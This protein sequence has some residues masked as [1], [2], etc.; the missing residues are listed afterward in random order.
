MS[1][2]RMPKRKKSFRFAKT[3]LRSDDP[4]F[5]RHLKLNICTAK[6]L[7]ADSFE[8]RIHGGQN[9]SFVKAGDYHGDH[10]HFL[11]FFGFFGAQKKTADPQFLVASF[12]GIIPQKTAKST[13]LIKC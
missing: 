8:F 10:S 1:C 4:V 13:V 9:F 2:S 6:I 11:T 12:I 3:L 5:F 7:F